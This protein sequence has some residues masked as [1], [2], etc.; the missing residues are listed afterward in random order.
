[1]IGVR[2]PLA[3]KVRRKV[4]HLQAEEILDL[5]R[6]N[7]H[8]DSAREAGDYRMR[9]VLDHR[10]ELRDPHDQE[11]HA[12]HQRRDREAVHSVLPDDPID[13]HHEGRG[14]A[15]DLDTR[16]TEC[17]DDETGDNRR[18]QSSIRRNA[19]GDCEGD[20]E[21]QRDD[22]DNNAGDRVAQKLLAVV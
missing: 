20:G 14:G 13:D 5:A 16:S 15:S 22:T 9:D 12:G 2:H 21:R 17:A 6:K 19:A 8:G 3:D 11:D 1:V 7:D 4:A 18:P 10:A